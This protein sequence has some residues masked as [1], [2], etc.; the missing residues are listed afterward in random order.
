MNWLT[1]RLSAFWDMFSLALI[2]TVVSLI[3]LFDPECVRNGF[4]E[5]I[6][7]SRNSDEQGD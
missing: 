1:K 6:E 4:K 7:D 3:A 5:A 2:L